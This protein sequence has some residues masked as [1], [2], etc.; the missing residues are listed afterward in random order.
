VRFLGW[1]IGV[2]AAIIAIVFAVHN[3]QI[4]TLDL[5][6]VPFALTAPLFAL[7]LASVLA[8]LLLG[9]LFAWIG[10]G[11]WR[12]LARQRGR[13]IASLK[14]TVAELRADKAKAAQRPGDG[15]DRPALPPPSPAAVTGTPAASRRP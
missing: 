15:A 5:W 4:L 1:V 7:V 8:G 10:A 11:R 6:P 2:V 14:A 12:R 9:W 3:H 13:D